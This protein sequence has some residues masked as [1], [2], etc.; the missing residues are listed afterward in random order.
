M[1][2]ILPPAPIDAPFG[3][4]NWANWYQQVRNVINAS[5]NVAWAAITGKPTTI[6]GYGIVDA[7]STSRTIS[8]TAPLTGGGDLTVDRTLSVSSFAAG[9]AGVVPASGGGTTNFLRADGSWAAPPGGG[10]LGAQGPAGPAVFLEADYQ[11]AE[12]FLVPGVPG[13][14]GATGATGAAGAAGIQ[15]APGFGF[16]GEDGQ[17]AW[18]I[19]GPAGPAGAAGVTGS[20]GASGPM[21]PPVFLDAPEGDEGPMGPPGPPGV[22]GISGVAGAAGPPGPAIF[23]EAEIYEPEM[24]LIPGPAG[25]TG[26]AGSGG[27]GSATIKTTTLTVPYGS[28]AYAA[29]VTDASVTGAS[30]IIVQHGHYTDVDTNDPDVDNIG[31]HVETVAVGSFLLEV[32][33]LVGTIGGPFKF[34]YLV[35]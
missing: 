29:T 18:P 4:Y 27:G 1:A 10:G 30:F 9:S 31:F 25:P 5:Q 23:L 2:D 14:T 12:M 17:D 20:T 13:P 6:A 32:S 11:E 7:L 35:G 28:S 15:G 3:S 16:D 24:F 21:G 22:A 26:P 19:P 8:T 34:N 33:A